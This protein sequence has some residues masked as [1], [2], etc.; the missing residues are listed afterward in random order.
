MHTTDYTKYVNPNI[1]TVG[2]LLQATYPNVQSPHGA[3]VVAPLYRPGMKDRYNSDKIFGFTVGTAAVMPTVTEEDPN[4]DNTAA[5]FDHDLEEAHPHF[6]SV[7]LESADI[8][9]RHT[10]SKNH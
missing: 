6:Y 5:T 3:A 8:E 10:A 1:G 4:L 9:S 2:H 7:W